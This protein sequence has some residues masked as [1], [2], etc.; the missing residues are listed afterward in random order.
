MMSLKYEKILQRFF[1]TYEAALKGRGIEGNTLSPL[2]KQ[3]EDFVNQQLKTPYTFQ[4]YHQ[5]IRRPID[6]YQFGLEFIRPLV[7][8]ESSKVLGLENV[9]KIVKQL[10]S[11]DNVVLLAN[12]Q[13]EVDPQVISLMLESYPKLAEE[14]IFVAGDRV[15]TDPLAIPLSM[16]RNLLCIY[17][18]KRIEHPPELKEKKLLHNQRT[19]K[20]MKELLCEGGKCIYVA[21]SGGRDRPGETGCVEVAPFDAQSIEMFWLMAQKSSKVTHFYPLDLATYDLLPPPNEI[22]LELGEVRKTMV[23]P[24]H[25]AFGEE[26][27][28]E[29]FSESESSDKK[30]KRLKRAEYIWGKVVGLY[31]EIIVNREGLS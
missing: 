6:Y 17:S 4:T 15:I 25:L 28:M 7:V 10:S 29:S 23:C 3:Y 31:Q 20:L 13:T 19:M 8:F 12:H 11:G 24:V 9:E 26:I 1:A 30:E 2:I 21:P 16:G 14:M 5:A 27:E 22:D 18:K